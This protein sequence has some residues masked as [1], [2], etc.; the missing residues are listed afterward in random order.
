MCHGMIVRNLRYKG[1]VDSDEAALYHCPTMRFALLLLFAIIA[2]LVHA[3]PVPEEMD[4]D[5][6]IA[7]SNGIYIWV[8]KEVIRHVFFSDLIHVDVV[9]F[10]NSMAEK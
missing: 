4:T 6:L 8:R 2:H 9:I 10:I 7:D 1:S 3:A 5:R